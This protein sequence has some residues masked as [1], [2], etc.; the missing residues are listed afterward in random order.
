MNGFWLIIKKLPGMFILTAIWSLLFLIGVCPVWNTIPGMILVI[1]GFVV[2][3]AEF[4]KSTRFSVKSFVFDL[5]FA[6][7][8]IITATWTG[9]YAFYQNVTFGLLDT[10][11]CLLVFADVIVSTYNSFS[12]A[13]R[14][15]DVQQ[16]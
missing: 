4:V 1:L 16:Q 15:I 9:A 6:V 7:F 12:L 11:I 3:I 10:F 8:A 5:I 2:M 14:R 13:F